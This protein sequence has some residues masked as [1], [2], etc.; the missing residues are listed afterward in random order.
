MN[1]IYKAS[2]PVKP[3]NQDLIPV[4]KMKTQNVFD[5]YRSLPWKPW[6]SVA[7]IDRSVFTLCNQTLE[8]KSFLFETTLK[9]VSGPRRSSITV[10]E[11]GD[12]ESPSKGGC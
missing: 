9:Y 6:T 11:F 10:T 4:M 2:S 5:L 12:L 8:A 3:E 7:S 1:A